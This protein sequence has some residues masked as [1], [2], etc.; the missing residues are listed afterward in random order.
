MLPEERVYRKNVNAG[1]SE[2]IGL[3]PNL[4]SR[5]I[6]YVVPVEIG[7]APQSAGGAQ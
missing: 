7:H 1:Y 3:P 2:A 4:D 6:K 5:Q